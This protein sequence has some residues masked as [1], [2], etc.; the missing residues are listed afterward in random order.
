MDQSPSS[1]YGRDGT[2]RDR[3]ADPARRPDWLDWLQRRAFLARELRVVLLD[4]DNIVEGI[5]VP[6]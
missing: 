2:S 5:C 3:R 6:G 1:A 4:H